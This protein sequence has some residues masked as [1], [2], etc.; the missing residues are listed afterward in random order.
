[1][2][3]EHENIEHKN[4]EHENAVQGGNICFIMHIKKPKY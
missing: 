4:A 2:V 1:M 3:C